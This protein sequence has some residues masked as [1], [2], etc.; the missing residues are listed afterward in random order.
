[1]STR[2]RSSRRRVPTRRSQIAFALGAS[3]RDLRGLDAGAGQGRVERFGELLGAV[4]NQEP[5]I[6]GAIAEVH[7]EIAAPW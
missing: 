5:E 6:G 3:R 7:K 4:A 1:M 2:S